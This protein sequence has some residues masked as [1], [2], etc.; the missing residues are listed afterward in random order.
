MINTIRKI[1]RK[2]TIRVKELEK[3]TKT[4]YLWLILKR[5]LKHT[6]EKCDPDLL[7]LMF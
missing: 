5:Y 6:K 7:I 3:L 1:E 2:E 4:T